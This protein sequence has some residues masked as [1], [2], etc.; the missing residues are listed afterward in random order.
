MQMRRYLVKYNELR[1]TGDEVLTPTGYIAGVE[2]PRIYQAARN[3]AKALGVDTDLLIVHSIDDL[4]DN[5]N[6]C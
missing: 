5:Y 1:L 2:A 3:A 4:D 6:I